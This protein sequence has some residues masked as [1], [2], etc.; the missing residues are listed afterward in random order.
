MER[1]P[2]CWWCSGVEVVESENQ[3]RA[4]MLRPRGGAI[5]GLSGERTAPSNLRG[6]TPS[7][8]PGIPP[9]FT[10]TLKHEFAD[11]TAY[12]PPCISAWFW[13]ASCPI[14]TLFESPRTQ[15][16][17]DGPSLPLRCPS[18]RSHL[19][20]LLATPQTAAMSWKLTKSASAMIA[21]LSDSI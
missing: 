18:F 14:A 11:P 21:R 17:R 7:P 3:W 16:P 13:S 10:A 15:A 9:P 6:L 2:Q 12:R 20:P 8:V 5:I 19:P 4:R 1:S